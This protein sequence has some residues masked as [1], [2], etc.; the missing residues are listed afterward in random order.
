[1]TECTALRVAFA[2]TPNFASV[3]LAELLASSHQVVGV[4]TQPDRPA[5]RGRQLTASPV[6][7]LAVEAGVP[8][9]QPASLKTEASLAT[10]RSWQADVL[11]VA[12][13]GIL[14]PQTVLQMP[15]LGCLN[16]HGSLLPRWRGA[17]PIHRA[18]MAGD[19]TTGVTIMRM[20]EGL[21]TGD[22]LTKVTVDLKADDTTLTVHDKLAALGATALV[23]VL[24][25]WCEGAIA[26]E[27]QPEAGVTY[28][29]KLKKDE[30]SIDFTDSALACDRLIRGL[31]GWPI[32]ES[33]LNGERIRIHAGGLST[34]A[35]PLGTA[36]GTILAVDAHALTVATGQGAVALTTLQRPGK[37][38]LPAADFA[39]GISCVGQVF[40]G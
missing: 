15:P 16:I 26:A 12:A 39:S 1:M 14:L 31:A 6:K 8:V 34:I 36:A 10:L 22:M 13:Y 17:A 29:H 32:A 23:E 28:A 37:K 7:Q 20:D 24:T 40:G 25:P 11:V 2:G 33:Q 21:D 35:V 9:D 30:A 38:A 18:I 19:K 3:A 4:L 27:P 5:G